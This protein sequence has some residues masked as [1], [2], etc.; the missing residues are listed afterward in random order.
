VADAAWS[1][2]SAN[3]QTADHDRHREEGQEVSPAEAAAIDQIAGA[4]GT[5]ES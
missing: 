5:K 3:Q 1:A 2:V 4:L